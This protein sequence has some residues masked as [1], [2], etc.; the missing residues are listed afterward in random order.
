MTLAY[1]TEYFTRYGLIT[2]FV[3]VLLENLNLPGFPS[4]LIMPFSGMMAARGDV[5]FFM[6]LV[7]T[8]G[9]GLCGSMILYLLGWK[10]GGRFLTAYQKRFPKQRAS[11]DK[12]IAWLRDRGC[13]AVFAAKLLPVVRTI[14][15][16]PAGTIRLDVSK[17]LISSLSGI[18]IWN[19]VLTGAG[20]YLGGKAID[21]LC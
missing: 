3:V 19:L 9:A 5:S 1:L 21:A 10:G 7:V 6:V 16:I 2:I 11:I 13:A 8:C 17:Y 12:N 18:F 4:G 14:I 20:Y 15:S